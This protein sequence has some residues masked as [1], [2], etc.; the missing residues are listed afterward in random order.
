MT[1]YSLAFLGLRL[2][3]VW[4]IL[5]QLREAPTVYRVIARSY[6]FG[7]PFTE[8]A[9]LL[10]STVTI[11]TVAS[12]IWIGAAILARRLVEI[13]LPQVVQNRKSAEEWLAI[14]LFVA[15][16]FLLIDALAGML[17]M[18]IASVNQMSIFFSR[19]FNQENLMQLIR[20]TIQ[21]ILSLLLLWKSRRINRVLEVSRRGFRDDV[22]T[23]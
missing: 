11:V 3:S 12:F 2:M 16:M 13:D 7:L 8:A 15:G 18:I 22:N 17:S 21:F 19:S 6:Y 20:D 5:Q 4:L 9:I 14:G 1:P 10:F 23:E